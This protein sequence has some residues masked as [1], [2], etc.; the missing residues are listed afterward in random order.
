VAAS[1]NQGNIVETVKAWDEMVTP[2]EVADARATLHTMKKAMANRW[3]G[4]G[5]REITYKL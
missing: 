5:L 1:N 3:E 4:R 2:I